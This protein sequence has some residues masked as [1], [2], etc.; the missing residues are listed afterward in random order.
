[1]VNQSYLKSIRRSPIYKYGFEI[2]RSVKHA[3]EL[4]A[5][6]GNTRWGDAIRT[7]ISQIV[8]YETFDDRGKGTKVPNA[9]KLIRCHFVFDVKHDGRHKARYVAGGHLTDPPLESVYSG[10]VSLRSLRL[11]IFLSELNSLQLYAA[12]VG[13]AYLE[14][15]TREHVC[16]IGGPEFHDVGLEGHLLIIV[17][18][19]YGLKTS[20]AR[21]HDRFA[22]TLRNEGF[23]PCKA[24]SDVWM[25]KTTGIIESHH[26]Y[27]YICVYVDDLAMA[28]QDPA[29]FCEILKN[30]Y[31][32]KLKGDGPLKYHLGCDFDREPDGTFCYGPFKY[33]GKMLETYER[34]FGE[35]P[36]G[37]SSPLEKGDHPELDLSPELDDNGRALYM[38]LVGQCQWLISLGRFDISCA[39]MTLSRFRAA[40]RE[41]HMK[42]I[43]RVFG[44]LKQYPK[45]A[46]RVRV[47]VPDY[48]ALPKP[49][50]D[51]TS[52]YGDTSDELPYDMPEPLGK[53][54]LTT[55]YVD[56]NLY[57]DYLTGRSVTG[58]LHL[59]N[60]TPVDWYCKRQAT[61]ETATYGSEFNAARTATEQIMDLRYTLRMLGVPIVHSY[62]FGD[63]KSVVLNSTVPHSQLNKRHNAL[64]YH[65]VREAIAAGIL[66]FFHIDGKKNPA[67]II[68]KHCGHLDAWPHIKPLLFWRG[69]TTVIPDKGE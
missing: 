29:A 61:V 14:A 6:N 36:T 52:V 64:A 39:L 27:E 1:M 5:K 35:K 12:D 34:V 25:R 11:V 24:D 13:N 41:G 32:Y 58:V 15:K 30:K 60:Q 8:E 18:A 51:W 7:E 50:Y 37:Y 63:N 57:H 44:Y 54:V 33:V 40:P 46:L 66:Q 3:H 56:A 31:N 49:T 4:D 21:W 10:V 28:M 45:G 26:L 38:S 55:S 59:V 67:D 42:R 23:T 47:G 53:A 9:Y 16:I 17:R 69:E 68:S 22:D 20:G 19:L 43:K 2:P 48:T 62:M 65:R